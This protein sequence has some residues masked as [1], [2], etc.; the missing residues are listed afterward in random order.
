MKVVVLTFDDGILSH[1]E[2][3]LPLLKQYGF[4]AT[5][6]ISG[7]LIDHTNRKGFL[8]WHQLA[9][10]H[11]DGFELG[12]HLYEHMRSSEEP[13]NRVIEHIQWIESK[14]S[15]LGLPK[16]VSLSYPGFLRNIRTM[17][18]VRK[19]GYRYARG[20]CDKVMSYNDYQDGGFGGGF[21]PAWDNWLN[22]PTS[23][24]GKKFRFN[25]FVG[26]LYLVKDN[27]IGVYCIHGFDGDG[28]I[29]GALDE[30]TNIPEED[31]DRCLDYLYVN[32]YK[33]IALKDVGNYCDF[34]VGSLQVEKYR[35]DFFNE[36]GNKYHDEFVARMNGEQ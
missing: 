3:V 15:K 25:E 32:D 34:H 1:L 6:F 16:P 11:T 23:L 26:S 8:N 4:K 35:E 29:G 33:V 5:F 36:H 19:L 27:E 10:F 7:Q 17:E 31:F 22:V 20:G 12:N 13:D 18:L 2:F 9:R 30:F 28:H 21:D 24:F 14:F